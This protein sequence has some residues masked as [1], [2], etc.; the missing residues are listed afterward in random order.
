MHRRARTIAAML[1][2]LGVAVGVAGCGSDSGSSDANGAGKSDAT[3]TLYNAQHEDLVAQMVS[4]F[5]KETGITVET[6]NGSDLEMA[7][8]IVQEGDRSPA[9]VFLTENS[10]GMSLVDSHN[11]FAQVDSATL[12]QV[13]ARYR[14]ANKHWVG[15]AARATVLVYNKSDVQPADLPR[16]I[17]DLSDPKWA[18]KFGYAPTGADF[19]AIV[20]AVLALEGESATKTWLDGL[21]KN[22]TAYQNNVATMKAVNDG[23]VPL[24]IIY[25][26]YW[27]QDQA[28]SGENSSNTELHFIG[29][30]DPGAFVSVSGAG[31]LQSSDHPTRG[32]ATGEVP[33]EQGRARRSSPTARRS[34]TRS[35]AACRPTTFSSRSPSSMHRRWIRASS[36]ASR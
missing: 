19:Q 34:S 8:Q 1:A 31:V 16:S 9:D 4:A 32:A 36:T 23:E 20:S 14:P 3:L 29:H 24:G 35:P 2:A 11:G 27:Y 5:T 13:P 21:K 25:H 33:H 7:N 12:S 28:E 26:Y 22:G 17:M 10:P 15:F 18:G 30:Q 6:R